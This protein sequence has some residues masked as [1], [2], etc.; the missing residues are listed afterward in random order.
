[1]QLSRPDAGHAA[2]IPHPGDW[3]Q[4]FLKGSSSPFDLRCMVDRSAGR[5]CRKGM[6]LIRWRNFFQQ[7]SPDS[8]RAEREV[9][10]GKWKSVGAPLLRCRSF[11]QP[12]VSVGAIGR[13]LGGPAAD[14]ASGGRSSRPFA[15]QEPPA[16]TIQGQ[17]WQCQAAGSLRT[18]AAGQ[19]PRP[20][21]P[22]NLDEIV[23]QLE[24]SRMAGPLPT[25]SRNPRLR[26]AAAGVQALLQLAGGPPGGR[27]LRTDRPP[28]VDQATRRA[29][30]VIGKCHGAI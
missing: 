24:G 6:V 23:V 20:A 16:P 28:G 5:P 25:F 17:R 9:S 10:Y 21:V 11:R 13:W 30:L 26:P 22:S 12:H 29:L 19:K 2:G 8:R 15:S 27:P 7:P 14:A 3:E 4:I 1:L 18:N